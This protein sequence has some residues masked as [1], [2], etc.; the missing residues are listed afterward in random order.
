MDDMR[1]WFVLLLLLLLLFS[2]CLLMPRLTKEVVLSQAQVLL[3]L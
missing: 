3:A 1:T 2:S